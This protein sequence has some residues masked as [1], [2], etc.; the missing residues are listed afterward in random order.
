MRNKTRVRNVSK[1]VSKV[2]KD[3]RDNYRLQNFKPK[4]KTVF[5]YQ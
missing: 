5:Y 4:F 3:V 2:R 1:V